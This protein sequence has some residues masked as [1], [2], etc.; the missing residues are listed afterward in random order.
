MTLRTR[1]ALGL[2]AI[3]LLLAAPL[4]IALRALK[5]SESAAMQLRGRDL[6]ASLVMARVRTGTLL[7]RR[8]ELAVLFSP[9]S[10]GSAAAMHAEM[11][12]LVLLADSL[13]DYRLN[14]FAHVLDRSVD[15]LRRYAPL[16]AAAVA[17]RDTTAADTLSSEHIVPAIGRIER[18]L[19][20]A[21]REVTMRAGTSAA[22]AARAA[23]EAQD[24]AGSLLAAAALGALV[25]GLWLGRTIGRPVRELERGMAAVAGGEF[26][27]QLALSPQRGDEFGRLAASYRQ[28][29]D[30]L[31]ELDRLKAE[32]VSVASHELKTPINVIKGY[33]QLLEEQLYG[34]LSAE[35]LEVLRTVDGQAQQLAR[36]V[37]H[38]LDVSRFQAGAGRLE[39]RPVAL[40]PFLAEAEQS[41][42]VLAVQRGLELTVT[43][44]AGL[45]EVVTWDPDRMIEV[46]SNLLSNAIKFTRTGGRVELA[47]RAEPGARPADD[48]IHLD[49]RDTGAGIPEA[50][51]PHIFGKFFQADNQ[52]AAALAGSGLGLAIAKEIVEAHGGSIGVESTLGQGSTFHV[53]VP[54]HATPRDASGRPTATPLPLVTPSRAHTAV[55]PRSDAA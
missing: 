27:H 55:A 6:A 36:L 22:E 25:V 5:Q 30:R 47:V 19:G 42:R 14:E 51:L 38:L 10:A 33:V 32:F 15:T 45:P 40:R 4:G 23:K 43:A 41:Y 18:A 26:G 7:L 48:R 8:W 16:Q 46:V 9:D 11:D 12:T 34:P 2:L 49:V 20:P 54:A 1:L 52:H 3:A 44:A 24:A 28:M 50:E 37:Q 39:L 17:R 31:A 53:A 35:Q 13:R 29:A 21:E